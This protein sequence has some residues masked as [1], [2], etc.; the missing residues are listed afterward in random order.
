MATREALGER[1]AGLSQLGVELVV[2]DGYLGA[3]RL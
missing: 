3:G 1:A 2:G